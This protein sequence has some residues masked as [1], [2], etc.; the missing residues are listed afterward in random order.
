LNISAKC[1]H[2]RSLQFRA[3]P[4]QSWCVFFWG[5]GYI[6]TN[7]NLHSFGGGRVTNN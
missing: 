5:T 3:I 7:P 6:R 4:F 2:N 1:H